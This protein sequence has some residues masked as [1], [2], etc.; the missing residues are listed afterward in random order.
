MGQ[1]EQRSPEEIRERAIAT[2]VAKHE[3]GCENCA[4]AYIDVARRNGATEEDIR[5]GGIGRRGFLKFAVA[6]L[7]ATGAASAVDLLRPTPSAKASVLLRGA[8]LGS[9][10][11]DSCTPMEAATG[12]AMP[13]QFY[14]AEVGATQYGLGCFNAGTASYVGPDFTHGYWGLC[15]PNNA[16]DPAVYGR[17][18]AQLAIEAL[19]ANPAVG[20]KTFFAD[21]ETGFG[22]WGDPATPAQNAALL[23]AFLSTIAAAGYIPGVYINDNSR[24]AWFAPDYV[25][26][27]PFVYW[28]AGGPDAGQM[29]APCT[30]NCDT[31][32]PVQQMWDA[33]VSKYTF[34]GYRAVL[35]QYW[36][37]N[38]GCGGDFNFSPQSAYHGF[39]PVSVH[40]APVLT[41]P[42]PGSTPSST[43]SATPSQTPAATPTETP[44]PIFQ[45][46]PSMG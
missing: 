45:P 22:G 2:A 21:V 25:A 10:G 1:I 14:V 5:R 36:L 24:D 29:C 27:V 3:E 34:G 44:A 35:W 32:T 40:D 46:T 9:F 26:A 37:S 18:Q 19:Q 13:L 23:D 8:Y 30:P 31:L 33:D 12:Q 28:V 41:K 43:P 17:L 4:A 11:V 39:A 20:A 6:L 38:F 42:Q 15:G 16:T 7:A